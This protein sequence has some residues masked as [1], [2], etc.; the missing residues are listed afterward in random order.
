[1]SQEVDGIRDLRSGALYIIVS[2]ILVTTA[3]IIASTVMGVSFLLKPTSA[4][5]LMSG[6]LGMVVILVIVALVL[7]I[8]WLVKTRSGFIKLKSVGRDVGSGDTGTLLIIIGIIV[9]IVGVAVAFALA[10]SLS[11]LGLFAGLA[12]AFIGA[13]IG[14]VG[15]I[16]VALGYRRVGEVYEESSL[17]T[18]GLLLLIG[19]IL[20]LIPII[21]IVG[22]IL[23]FIGFI[24]VYIGCGTL[25]RRLPLQQQYASVQLPSLQ[26]SQVGIGRVFS[27]GVAEVTIYS[28]YYVQIVSAVL[29]GVNALSISPNQLIPGNNLVRIAFPPLNLIPGSTYSV[30]LYLSNGQTL[31]VVV[32]AS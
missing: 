21:D 11:S 24:L 26:P 25:L 10:F 2:V 14:L 20:D 1:M 13:I 16:L 30:Q 19:F 4:T 15:Q 22:G 12:I 6:L 8:L 31:T 3:D 18:G 23:A 27:N 17:K 32:I 29:Q 28:P 5:V 7:G 9:A